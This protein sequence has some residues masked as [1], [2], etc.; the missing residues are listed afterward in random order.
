MD[1]GIQELAAH[2][3]GP[4]S[5]TRP[6]REQP[7][8]VDFD[9]R[10]AAEWPGITAEEV[11]LSPTQ[12]RQLWR[13]FASDSQLVVQQAQATQVCSHHPP[14]RRRRALWP[15]PQWQ[16]SRLLL[17]QEANRAASNQMPP[18]WAL[19]AMVVLGFN[20]FLA[21]LY[22]PLMLLLLI[23][24]LLFAKTVYSELDI[25]AEM[26]AGL[27]PGLLSIMHKLVPT[28]T[29]VRDLLPAALEFLVRKRAILLGVDP[30][31]RD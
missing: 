19:A 16:S 4:M 23:A 17:A 22:N 2:E 11:L 9:I 30:P 3:V 10:S 15:L 26:E 7:A 28:V 27:L 29:L 8:D 13:Q 14:G 20:E 24:L 6:T 1:E 21:L 18:L 5:G 12:C 31:T 25:D